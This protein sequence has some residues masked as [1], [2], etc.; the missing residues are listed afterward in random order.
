M[1]VPL[2]LQQDSYRAV[3]NSFQRG[4]EYGRCCSCL[5]RIFDRERLESSASNCP[6]RHAICLL[7]ILSAFS[8]SFSRSLRRKGQL[9]ITGRLA[10][11]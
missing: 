10:S 9:E 4:R 3:L 11:R 7:P 2:W 6:A 1:S 8:G 5:A